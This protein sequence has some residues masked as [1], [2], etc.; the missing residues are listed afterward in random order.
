MAPQV[1]EPDAA[2]DGG[3]LKFTS[4]TVPAA[5]ERGRATPRIKTAVACAVPRAID[6][7]A[8]TNSTVFAA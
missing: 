6:S 4:V 8:H 1:A 5:V 2:A 7:A 3:T